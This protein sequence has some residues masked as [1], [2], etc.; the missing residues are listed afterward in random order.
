MSVSVENLKGRLETRQAN[1]VLKEPLFKR[2]LRKLFPDQRQ[3]ERISVPP[4]VAYL[5]TMRAT[6]PYEIGDI[7][8]SGFSLV[9]PERWEVGTEMPITLQRTNPAEETEADCFTVQATVVRAGHQGVGFSL[10]LSEEES[11]AAHG[12]QLRVKWASK[13][14][15]DRFLQRLN[16][17]PEPASAEAEITRTEA[18]PFLGA[19]RSA[20]THSAGD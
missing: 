20:F 1:D 12:N 5:G 10:V 17:E 16:G 9:T 13:P 14:E 19:A 18:A 11:N 3:Q 15:M 2:L 8:G 7:S 4:L 6:K